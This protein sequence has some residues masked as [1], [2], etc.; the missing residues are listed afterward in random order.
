MP[1]Y[2]NVDDPFTR[3]Q[4][5]NLDRARIDLARSERK[6][7]VLERQVEDFEERRAGFD[8]SAPLL[9]GAEK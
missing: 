8:S 4:L 7:A 6:R 5:R 2:F 3:R 1:R 9:P